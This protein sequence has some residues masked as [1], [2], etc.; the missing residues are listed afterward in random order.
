MSSILVHPELIIKKAIKKATTIGQNKH[1]IHWQSTYLLALF[2]VIL[3]VKRLSKTYSYFRIDW[4]QL[5]KGRWGFLAWLSLRLK[6]K[7]GTR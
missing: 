5:Q 3:K 7:M 6:S 2:A 1:I 4:V